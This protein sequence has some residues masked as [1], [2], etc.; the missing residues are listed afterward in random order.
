VRLDT[1]HCFQSFRITWRLPGSDAA[2]R[3]SPH[4]HAQTA[5][6]LRHSLRNAATG[7]RL[8]QTEGLDS[9]SLLTSRLSMPMYAKN[10]TGSSGPS[11]DVSDVIRDAQRAPPKAG[12]SSEGFPL[13]RTDSPRYA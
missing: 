8:I 3:K 6:N 11:I 10:F 7:A 12:S 5:Q 13:I 9:Q 1:R 4:N 2:G